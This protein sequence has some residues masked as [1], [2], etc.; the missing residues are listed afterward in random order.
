VGGTGKT[1]FVQY[2]IPLLS[3][4]FPGFRFTILSRGYKAKMS[5]TGALVAEDSLPTDVGDEPLLHKQ[6]LPEVQV[7]IGSDRFQSFDAFNQIHDQK[8]IV[9]LDDGFQHHKLT[10][11]FDIVLIDANRPLGNGFTIPLGILRESFSALKRADVVVFTKLNDSNQKKI[12][13]IEESLNLKI[14]KLAKFRSR[15]LP[16][17]QVGSVPG[18]ATKKYLLIMGVGNPGSVINTA[19]EALGEVELEIKTFPDHHNYT[20]SEMIE[21]LKATSLDVS[22]VTTEKDWVKW[23][24]LDRFMQ[25]VKSRKV[26]ILLI[27]IKLEMENETEFVSLLSSRVSTYAKEISLA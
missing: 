11:D 23:R 16:T 10:R 2:L 7:I 4:K 22:L 27:Q 15:F 6:C 17:I 9:L 8:H 19:K 18:I 21:V 25:E 24:S 14:P 20:D 13:S 12:S 5:D 3:K 26:G 1:P